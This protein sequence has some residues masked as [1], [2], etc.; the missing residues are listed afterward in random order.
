MQQLVLE[1]TVSPTEQYKYSFVIYP[2]GKGEHE[3]G[4]SNPNPANYEICG[5]RIK[6][7]QRQVWNFRGKYG[8]CYS[9]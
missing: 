5:K 4:T 9:A 2:E 1:A 7:A 8:D 6:E 3:E